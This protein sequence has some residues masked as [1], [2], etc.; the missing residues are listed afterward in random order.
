M[1]L[2]PLFLGLSVASA[3]E[4]EA[5]GLLSSRLN[6]GLDT[7]QGRVADCRLLDLGELVVVQGQLRG[8]VAPRVGLG[9]ELG[10][11]LRSGLEAQEV[12]DTQRALAIQAL[13]PEVGEAWI[14]LRDL[15]VDGVD[16]RLGQQQLAWGV[17]EGINPVNTVNPPDLRDPTR[18]D[19]RLGTPAVTARLHRG[20]AS[21]ELVWAPLFRPARL[22]VELDLLQDAD[23][24]FDF[25]EVG[26][27][28]LVLGEL[29][30]RT[31]FPDT[32]VGFASAGARAALAHR[33]VDLAVVGWTG[34]EALPQVGGEALLVGFSTRSELVDV[35]IP[36][37]YPRSSLLGLELRGELPLQLLGWAEG[38]LV[39][40]EAVS[41]RASRGQ[42]QGL[43]DLGLIDAIPEPLPETV[44]Q[45]G[46]PFGRWVVGVQRMQGP[47]VLTL[48]WIHGLP[49]ERARADCGDYAAL[50]ALVNLGDTAR[51][52]LRGV[53]DVEGVLAS[54]HLESLHG[55][56]ATLRL[57][58]TLAR[59]PEGSTLGQLRPVSSAEVGVEVSF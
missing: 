24:L 17:A 31:A 28:E 25:A 7:C 46:L 57:G 35:G 27:E 49:T 56:A 1:A 32:R 8:E 59:G 36:V 48:Q 22:P 18:F 12:E 19:R 26:G 14:E 45:D 6:L 21:F 33:V 2:L 13:E 23:Q 20:N 16:L 50:G 42:L 44:I 55:D 40:P 41:V 47:M 52:D 58:A 29:E 37:L 15:G 10:V 38:A 43:V 30:T 54:A 5:S 53:T 3:G 39:F 9:L 51:L 4:L 34:T 11:R